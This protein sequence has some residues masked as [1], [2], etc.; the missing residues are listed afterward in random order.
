MA[1][2]SISSDSLEA[3]EQRILDVS[4]A[5]RSIRQQMAAEQIDSIS[6][7]VR[8]FEG[9]LERLE[10]YGANF[11]HALRV[12]KSVSAHRKKKKPKKTAKK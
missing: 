11:E 7:P 5:L 8:T 12:N 3:F 6:G 2:Q 4:L 1:N 9:A 10:R